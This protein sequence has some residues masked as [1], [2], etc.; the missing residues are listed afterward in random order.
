MD[1]QIISNQTRYFDVQSGDGRNEHG[2]LYWNWRQAVGKLPVLVFFMVRLLMVSAEYNLPLLH[3]LSPLGKAQN[4]DITCR[5]FPHWRN[6]FVPVRHGSVF[7][8]CHDPFIFLGSWICCHSCMFKN[9]IFPPF[10]LN[11][12]TVVIWSI[13]HYWSSAEAHLHVGLHWIHRPGVLSLAWLPL[14]RE[15]AWRARWAEWCSVVDCWSLH[16]ATDTSS[17]NIYEH[18]WATL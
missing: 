15:G 7:A 13:G 12:S 14:P 16:G 17:S 9:C 1:N 10:F 2:F 3:D 4:L 8:V 5:L 6:C 18:L 11:K